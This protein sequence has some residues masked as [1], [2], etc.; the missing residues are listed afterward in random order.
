[1]EKYVVYISATDSFLM[2]GATPYIDEKKEVKRVIAEE[3][4]HPKHYEAKPTIFM[5]S[6]AKRQR[7]KEKENKIKPYKFSPAYPEFQYRRREGDH[8]YLVIV[9]D[10]NTNK[11]GLAVKSFDKRMDAVIFARKS[12]SGLTKEFP[13]LGYYILDTNEYTYK[14]GITAAGEWRAEDYAVGDS[15]RNSVR[16]EGADPVR[17]SKRRGRKPK[18]A[19][20]N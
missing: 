15:V 8:R 14:D 18:S 7:Q 6:W 4:V 9:G 11:S 19:T 17:Q 2:D 20:E 12:I 5:K 13:N 3:T 16:P 1:M 10:K